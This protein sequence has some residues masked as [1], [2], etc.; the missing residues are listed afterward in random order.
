MTD[1]QDNSPVGIMADH[2][3]IC[4]NWADDVEIDSDFEDHARKTCS[5]FFVKFPGVCLGFT[6]EQLEQCGHD[7]WLTRQGHGAGFWARDDD[8]FGS[9]ENRNNFDNYARKLGEYWA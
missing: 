6:A 3:S 7:L 2:Y 4:A 1:Q 8:T 9:P 5:D